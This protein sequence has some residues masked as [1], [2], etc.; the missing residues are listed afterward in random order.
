MIQC[1]ALIN[2]EP[3]FAY[4]DS[5]LSFVIEAPCEFLMGMDVFSSRDDTGTALREYHRMRR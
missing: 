3:S 4:D 5:D 2:H 1:V